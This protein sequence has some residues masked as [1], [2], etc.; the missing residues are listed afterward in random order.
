MLKINMIPFKVN[1]PERVKGIQIEPTG[2]LDEKQLYLGSAL[3]LEHGP[4]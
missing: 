3:L 4:K 2:W 1:R